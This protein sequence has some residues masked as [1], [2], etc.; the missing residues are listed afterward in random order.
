[1]IPIYSLNYHA[2][3]VAGND[4]NKEAISNVFCMYT[5]HTGLLFHVLYD[6]EQKHRMNITSGI[7]ENSSQLSI[8]VLL[9]SFSNCKPTVSFNVIQFL[10]QTYM[11]SLFQLMWYK[12]HVY[13]TKNIIC[14]KYSIQILNFNICSFHLSWSVS[15]QKLNSVP[16]CNQF[17]LCNN[18]KFTS[19]SFKRQNTSK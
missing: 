5:E 13:I 18:I 9:I 10:W 3:G 12:C 14:N 19:E 17:V 16:W 2:N 8:N 15:K 4:E 11:R 1:M 7:R 6:N